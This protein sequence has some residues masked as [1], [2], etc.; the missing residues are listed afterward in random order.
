M[1]FSELRIFIILKY[2]LYIKIRA[3]PVLFAV[4]GRID[5]VGKIWGDIHT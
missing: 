1:F 4:D 5:I 3:R 2:I